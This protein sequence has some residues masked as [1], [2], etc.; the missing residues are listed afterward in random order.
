VGTETKPEI[1][2]PEVAIPPIVV[3]TYHGNR[4]L[5]SKPCEGSGDVESAPGDDSR[6]GEPEIEQVAIDQQ[7]VAKLGDRVEELEQCLLGPGWRHSQVG[8][9]HDDEGTAEHG[10]KDGRTWSRVQPA[11]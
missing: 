9:G 2:F 10:A 8:V 5:E 1:L 11:V 4:D 7:A 3:P 6:I